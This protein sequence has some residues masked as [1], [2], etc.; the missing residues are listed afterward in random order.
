MV[1]TRFAQGTLPTRFRDT[2][3]GMIW[4]AFFFDFCVVAQ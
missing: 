2:K 1:I 3:L 4:R